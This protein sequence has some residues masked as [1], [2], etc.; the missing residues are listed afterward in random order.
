MLFTETD[1][2]TKISINGVIVGWVCSSLNNKYVILHAG[3]KG[4]KVDELFDRKKDAIKYV[5][6]NKLMFYMNELTSGSLWRH[7]GGQLYRIVCLSNLKAKNPA[8][9]KTVTYE[10]EDGVYWSRPISEFLD[11][12]KKEDE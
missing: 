8:F 10:S 9:L 4:R 3:N 5:V 7:F 1:V 11:R 6:D 2:G 12:F